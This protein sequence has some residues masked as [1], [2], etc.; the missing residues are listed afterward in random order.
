[1]SVG[2]V[3]YQPNSGIGVH[4]PSVI[5]LYPRREVQD[6]QDAGRRRRG[7]PAGHGDLPGAGDGRELFATGL[8]RPGVKAQKM[9]APVTG[10]QQ[11]A[12]AVDDG[13]AGELADRI[14]PNLSC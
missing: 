11:L 1:M 12:I 13:A 5:R 10:V 7:G 3:G 8:F 2:G 6:V 9:T 14:A 4:A